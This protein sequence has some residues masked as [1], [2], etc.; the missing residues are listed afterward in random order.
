MIY[1]GHNH[2]NCNLNFWSKTM[3]MHQRFPEEFREGSGGRPEQLSDEEV[4]ELRTEMIEL[5]KKIFAQ[6]KDLAG[7]ELVKIN[8]QKLSSQD[9]MFFK[10]LKKS[11]LAL[12][13]WKNSKAECLMTNW[14]AQN[15]KVDPR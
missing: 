4:A 7:I 14:I 12:K 11:S 6:G 1:S 13:T 10:K 15:N 8:P 5:Q 9:L 3:K 2:L